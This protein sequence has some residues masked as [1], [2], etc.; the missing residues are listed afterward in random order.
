MNLYEQRIRET[1]IIDET[2]PSGL[3]WNCHARKDF[4]GKPA[5]RMMDHG[6]F[7]VSVSVKG[8]ARQ[9]YAHRVVWFL[10]NGKWPTD[11]IDHENG[12]RADNN[13][14]NLREAS[15]SKNAQNKTLQANN[16]SGIKGVSFD[17]PSGKWEAR[18][19]IDGKRIRLGYFVELSDAEHAIRA[20]RE[21]HH[22]EFSNH[23]TAGETTWMI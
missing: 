22:G 15:C 9:F 20:A 4:I 7:R 10:A 18:L 12:D 21:K 2:S 16:T 19:K 6:Y 8:S 14:S 3:R 17:K 5:G 1:L 11:Q 23:G 13:L